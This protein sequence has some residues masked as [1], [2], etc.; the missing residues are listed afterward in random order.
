MRGYY[1]DDLKI[2]GGAGLRFAIT[3]EH[4]NVRLDYGLGP[5]T[6]GIYLPRLRSR[7]N[8]RITTNRIPA[9]DPF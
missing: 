7:C 4:L 1:F 3:E 2:A 9:V 8:P 6:D 5:N